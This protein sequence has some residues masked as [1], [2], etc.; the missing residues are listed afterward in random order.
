MG[1]EIETKLFLHHLLKMFPDMSVPEARRLTARE[2]NVLASYDWVRK[3]I[4]E[5]KNSMTFV[6][7]VGEIAGKNLVKIEQ[8]VTDAVAAITVE[9]QKKVASIIENSQQLAKGIKTKMMSEVDMR[10]DADTDSFSNDELI[11][12]AKTMHEIE[13]NTQENQTL[14]VNIV[15]LV[16]GITEF[17]KRMDELKQR[18]SPI[19]IDVSGGARPSAPDGEV[20]TG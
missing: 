5:I 3:T 6:A 4:S 17:N 20:Q 18:T 14:N 11:R 19:D 7:D 15:D 2:L 16:G 10:L 1:H 9:S 13:H 8:S 12:G